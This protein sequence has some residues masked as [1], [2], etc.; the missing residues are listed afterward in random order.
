[1]IPLLVDR[2][3]ALARRM[4]DLGRLTF[5]LMRS[6]TGDDAYERYLA[7]H[8]GHGH[9]LL[10]KRAFYRDYFDRRAQRPRCC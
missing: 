8:R 5:Q 4:S 7:Q 6:W 1:M 2:I 3:V 9:Q 10:T